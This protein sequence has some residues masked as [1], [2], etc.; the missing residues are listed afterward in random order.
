MMKP[1]KRSFYTTKTI[2][3]IIMIIAI[4]IWMCLNISST[5][6]TINNSLSST[7]AG[8]IN[9][10]QQKF[11][12]NIALK[13]N[14]KISTIELLNRDK[15]SQQKFNWWGV[16]HNSLK[17]QLGSGVNSESREFGGI[18]ISNEYVYQ[19][20]NENINVIYI[21]EYDTNKIISCDITAHK[22]VNCSTALT[23]LAGPQNIIIINKKIYIVNRITATI[24]ACDLLHNGKISSCN[25][26]PLPIKDPIHIIYD[27]GGVF[28]ISN[29]NAK[30][31]SSC[32]LDNN[33]NI[34]MCVK[35]VG[36]H[37]NLF[38]YTTL[39]GY[40]YSPGFLV[41]AINKCSNIYNE[42]SCI[43][44]KDPTI[45]GPLTI[46]ILNNYAYI[47]SMTNSDT[48]VTDITSCEILPNGDFTGCIKIANNLKLAIGL[49]V[50]IRSND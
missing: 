6:A 16:F 25:N 50:Y 11:N 45:K 49:A 22:L 17:K 35:T 14:S 5:N 40:G 41:N 31:I 33:G 21:S 37:P 27:S 2:K 4:I 38:K 48:Q 42:P 39:S 29:F 9:N 15:L 28:Y 12:E 18:A 32:E 8:L 46:K 36:I 7:R 47:I 20:S 30:L 34:T 19:K 24:T 44:I 13:N 23:G 1:N 10:S 43:Q 26:T 3:M